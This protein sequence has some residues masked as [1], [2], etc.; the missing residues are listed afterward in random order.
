MDRTTEKQLLRLLVGELSE[1]K[2]RE[3]RQRLENE[4]ELRQ[5]FAALQERWES[6]DLPPLQSVH[7]SFTSRVVRQAVT[8]PSVGAVGLGRS[9]PLWTRATAAVAL[10]GG[11]L[12]GALLVSPSESE[13]WTAWDA[14]ELTQAE[15]YWET[16]S[17]SSDDL[18][19]EDLP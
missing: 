7:P 4:G 2:A 8:G 14:V 6:L 10:A 17:V 12:V 18:V 1:S 3:I 11:I 16:M 15:V 19:Q 5:E 9:T 13:D